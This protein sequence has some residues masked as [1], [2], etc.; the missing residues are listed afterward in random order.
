LLGA[1]EVEDQVCLNE[2]SGRDV[3]DC[4]FLVDVA[5]EELKL[6]LKSTSSISP[7]NAITPFS[8]IPR[9]QTHTSWSLRL[10]P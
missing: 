3:E 6:D 1:R 7:S 5:G 2:G 8:D 4:D 10:V 9:L